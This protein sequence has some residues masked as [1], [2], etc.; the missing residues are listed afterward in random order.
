MRAR[1][2]ALAL[3]LVAAPGWDA[4]A[5]EKEFMLALHPA[6][7]LARVSSGGGGNEVSAWGGG[8]ALDASYG[9]NDAVALRVTGAFTAHAL[10]A[11]ALSRMGGCP[12][13]GDCSSA[14]YAYH[15]GAGISYAVD[16]LRLVPYFDLALG[17]LGSSYTDREGNP[18]HQVGFGV[19]IGIGA[20][21]LV[22]RLLSVGFVVR[23]HAYLTAIDRIPVYLYAGPRVALHFGG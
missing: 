19:E 4:L 1:L 23:Y 7:A 5:G 3:V 8:A 16:V 9:I 2:P 17:V 15:A 11:S 20:D 21:Y 10:D 18:V 6:F 14:L 13:G 12:R 22:S